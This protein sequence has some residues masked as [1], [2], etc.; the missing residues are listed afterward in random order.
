MVRLTSLIL[1]CFLLAAF[2]AVAEKPIDPAAVS[3][4]TYERGA[5]VRGALAV[6]LQILLDRAHASPGMIDGREGNNVKTALRM[7]EERSNL[8]ADGKLSARVWDLLQQGTTE[9]VLVRYELTADD[10]KGPFVEKIPTD[11]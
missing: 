11:Y 3:K 1:S 6:K 8:P 4:A 9:D 10:L 5:E 2:P 7:F